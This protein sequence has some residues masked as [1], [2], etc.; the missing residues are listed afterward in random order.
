MFNATAIVAQPWF[1]EWS[2]FPMAVHFHNSHIPLPTEFSCPFINAAAFEVK[3][4]AN[5]RHGLL[6]CLAVP[7][8]FEVKPAGAR[9]QITGIA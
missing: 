5:D 2:K 7:S 9:D 1:K 8:L 4:F 6:M 3:G